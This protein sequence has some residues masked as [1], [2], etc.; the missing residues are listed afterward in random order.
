MNLE[1]LTIDELNEVVKRA[2]AIIKSKKDNLNE[3]NKEKLS[4]IEAGKRVKLI[5]KGE[6]IV[7]IFVK[8]TSSRF[9]VDVNG[10]KKSILFDKLISTEV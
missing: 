4:K 7:A 9:T 2:K 10:A 6:P 5:F 3:A 1:N 8:I